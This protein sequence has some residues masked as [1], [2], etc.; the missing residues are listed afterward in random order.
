MLD[1]LKEQQAA[2]EL[3]RLLYD[4]APGETTFERLLAAR[5]A[6]LEAAGLDPAQPDGAT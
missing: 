6:A 2:Y 3:A 4:L 1:A 5:R